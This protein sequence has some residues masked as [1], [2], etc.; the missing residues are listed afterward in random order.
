M[1]GGGEE[2]KCQY[3]LE[4][5]HGIFHDGYSDPVHLLLLLLQTSNIINKIN[6]NINNNCKLFGL[7]K[8]KVIDVVSFF[9]C[10]TKG[11][12]FYGTVSLTNGD[13]LK[14]KLWR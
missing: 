11:G 1:S 2:L 3:H 14:A 9:K 5:E 4:L 6:K 10:M 12:F 8:S 7:L 13:F